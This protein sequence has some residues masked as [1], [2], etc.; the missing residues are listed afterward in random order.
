MKKISKDWILT[1]SLSVIVVLILIIDTVWYYFW[2]VKNQQEIAQV[3]EK[4][5]EKKIF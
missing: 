5:K 3:E 2:E 4:I 1:I